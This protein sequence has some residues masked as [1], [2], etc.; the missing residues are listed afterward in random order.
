VK[1]SFLQ[2]VS[3]NRS[4]FQETFIHFCRALA[5]ARFSK[6]Y[7]F[8]FFFLMSVPL[9]AINAKINGPDS[10]FLKKGWHITYGKTQFKALNDTVIVVSSTTHYS[11]SRISNEHA[12]GFYDSLQ[13]KADKNRFTRE[14]YKLTMRSTSNNPLPDT[15]QLGK[16]ED[17]FKPY[18][19]LIIKDIEFC[20]IDVFGPSV[21]DTSQTTNE[22]LLNQANK[23][24][25]DTRDYVIRQNLLF[26]NGDTVNP[27]VFGDNERLLRALPYLNNARIVITKIGG[28]SVKVC[29][30]TKDLFP[31]GLRLD[32]KNTELLNLKVWN[33]N[34][35]GLGHEISTSTAIRTDTTPLL[36]F[37][38]GQYSVS[39]IAGTFI[40]GSA[41]YQRSGMD[42]TF[43]LTFDRA[44]V[45]YKIKDALGLGLYYSTDYFQQKNSA[46]GATLT[47]VRY[48][49]T[50]FYYGHDFELPEKGLKGKKDTYF[51]IM[52]RF[53]NKNFFRR[54]FVSADSNYRYHNYTR[55]L[56]SFGISRNDYYTSDYIY[57]YGRTEDIPFGYKIV[58]TTGYVWGD[59]YNKIYYGFTIAGGEYL[60]KFGYLS[61]KVNV[62]SFQRK[63][64]FEDGALKFNM[65]YATDLFKLGRSKLRNIVYSNYTLG[66]N[67]L[68]KG[69]TI[70]LDE[71]V[72]FTDV[73]EGVLTGQQRFAFSVNN[74]L[75]LPWEFYGFRFALF[76]FIDFGLVGDSNDA[77][78][79]ET[80]YTSMGLGVGIKNANLVISAIEIRFTFFPRLIPDKKQFEMDFES[81][82][83]LG[84]E[85]YQ[86][87]APGVIS[88]N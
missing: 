27:Y 28:D 79:S 23:I 24:H 64:S 1:K 22:W 58:L 35:L 54:P 73:S 49:L 31:Y 60:K 81:A 4:V 74:V 70:S 88:F 26:K 77:I 55:F 65:T 11:I 68:D 82:S 38:Y 39:N 42:K 13:V 62:G 50:D 66:L 40:N 53:T 8:S 45:P 17:P 43:G 10:V 9:F 25:F 84:F 75:Y 29:V 85:N 61:A 76:S 7:F 6:Q 52:G 46:L 86:I 67:R 36:Q 47:P 59:F 80:L 16:V 33:E 20:K 71:S 63:N 83:K 69:L 34:F 37:D 2:T 44:F 56:T 78:F 57:N 19:G 3:G 30:I 41:Q 21:D 14:L 32:A 72:S 18:A 15:V 87:G 51:A 5:V 12:Q 48:F